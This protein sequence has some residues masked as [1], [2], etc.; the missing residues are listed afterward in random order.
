MSVL[1]YNQTAASNTTLGS[2]PL[3]ESQTKP[4]HLNN[5]TRQMMA[6]IAAGLAPTFDNAAALAAITTMTSATLT[7][8]TC[9]VNQLGLYWYDSSDVATAHNGTTVIVVTSTAQRYKLYSGVYDA[10]LAAIAGLTSAADKVPY[11]TGSGTAALADFTAA[12]R[13][14]VDDAST[15]AQRTTLGLGTAATQNTGTSGTNVPLLDGANT[16]SAGQ[17]LSAALNL[18]SGQIVFPATQV[19][20]SGANTLDDFEEGTWTLVI[21][22]ATPGDLAISAYTIQAGT[23]QKVGKEVYFSGIVGVAAGNFTHTTASS[24]LEITG[25]PFTSSTNFVGGGAAMMRGYTKAG[26]DAQMVE[27]SN[28]T[29]CYIL[30]GGSGVASAELVA[31]DVPTATTKNIFING[32]YQA[33]G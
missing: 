7:P 24:F 22:F 28:S 13:A 14:L 2:Q 23:Y 16:W 18:T 6:D 21:T 25:F 3:Q 4:K 26:F 33:T 9:I 15:A 32:H 30:V 20:S 5:T 29:F 27:M 31:A 8:R 1:D 12:G 19:P 11:F 10:E 17:T